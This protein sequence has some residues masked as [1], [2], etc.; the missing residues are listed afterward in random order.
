MFNKIR[1]KAI[2]NDVDFTASFGPLTIYRLL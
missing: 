1:F 2:D